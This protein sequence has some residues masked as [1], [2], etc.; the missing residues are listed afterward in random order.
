MAKNGHDCKGSQKYHCKN[1]GSYGTLRAPS[2]ATERQRVH[3]KRALYLDTVAE[4]E[5]HRLSGEQKTGITRD[6][7][8]KE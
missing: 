4:L 2:E 1:C 5:C 7:G 6:I 3:V 8:N